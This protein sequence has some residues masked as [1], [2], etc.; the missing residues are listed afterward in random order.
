MRKGERKK[1]EGK[2]KG[3]KRK[4]EE[5]KERQTCLIVVL[6]RTRFPLPSN[7]KLFATSYG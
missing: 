6:I 2:K 4:E 1:K 3:K 7:S 5:R